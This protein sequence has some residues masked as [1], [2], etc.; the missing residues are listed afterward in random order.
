MNNLE[1]KVEALSAKLNKF[2]KNPWIAGIQASVLKIV[3]L[4]LVSTLVTIYDCI[5]EFVPGLPSM[6]SLGTYTFGI[7]GLV[8]AMLVP[9]YI[10][11]KIAD[12]RKI[13]ASISSVGMFLM[14]MMPIYTEEGLAAFN[15]DWFGATGMFAAIVIGV[16]VAW[17]FSLTRKVQVFSEETEMPD[18]CKEWF[19]TMLPMAIIFFVGWVITE[20]VRFDVFSLLFTIFEPVLSGLGNT[21]GGTVFI[22]FIQIFIYTFGI[23]SWIIY[24][25]VGTI[26]ETALAANMSAVAAGQKAT[27]VY[28]G[29]MT[30]A[31]NCIGGTGGTLPLNL[32]ML[33]SK[34]KR[35]NT[36]G[37]VCIVP[38]L[39][40]INEP[41]MYSTVVFNPILMIPAWLSMIANMTISYFAI[42]SGIV[43]AVS[44]N[45]A[46]W[47]API[48]IQGFFLGG[49]PGACLAIVNFLVDAAI[50][51]P[52]FKVYEKQCLKQ[53]EELEEEAEAAELTAA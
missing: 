4:T 23:S 41:I 15:W 7:S 51:Y 38:S 35:L 37:K 28:S 46:F 6:G 26:L 27:Y 32:Y 43:P 33:K 1:S 3:P 52:F 31:Y 36:L 19:D 45:F 44:T 49:I 5:R 30:N 50:W 21:W 17:V 8:V 13:M 22:E 39:M 9:Y 16:F 14:L 47:Y 40:N 34:S 29:M 2:A 48:P 10:V 42:R 18:F 11:E 25:L 24:P 20:V 12:S 53:E